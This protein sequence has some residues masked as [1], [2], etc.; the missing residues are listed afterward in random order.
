MQIV[1]KTQRKKFKNSDCCTAF[2]YPINDSDINGAIIELSGRYPKN[3]FA[4]N[5]ICKEMGYVISGSGKIVVENKEYLIAEGDLIL[6][7]P[8][9][10]F[11]WEGSLQI[12]M[13]CALA[14]TPEQH[15]I[16]E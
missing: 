1:G 16:T 3:G 8:N 7:Q 10:K 14:W 15:R 6:I 9:E 4:V 2:E 13:P 11:Y 5:E 12:F